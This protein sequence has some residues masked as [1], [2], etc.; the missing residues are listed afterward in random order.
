MTSNVIRY[1]SA[2]V[3]TVNTTVR[4][5]PLPLNTRALPTFTITAIT[6]AA[7]TFTTSAITNAAATTVAVTATPVALLAG[8]TLTFTSTTVTLTADAPQ[9]STSLTIAPSP[10][11]IASAATATY[12]PVANALG[13]FRLFVSPTATFL[14]A[15]EQL[16]FGG[17]TAT[18]TRPAPLGSRVL[19][20]Q[21]LSGAVANNAT[22]ST[23]ALFT[24]VGATDASPSS[25]PKTTDTTNYTSGAG[26]EMAIIGTNRTL[27]VSYNQIN[28][29]LGAI[30]I[31]QILFNDAQFNR[32]VYARIVRANGEI[33][34]G[35][36]IVTSGDGQS[37]VQEKVTRT[38]NMQFQ[39]SSFV[40]TPGTI[41]AAALSANSV[42][43]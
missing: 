22:A 33:Y 15:G 25:A 41:D 37:P 30:A 10:G 34:E 2:I 1:P 35:A 5:R 16:T 8:E 31:Q 12:T 3:T 7:Q 4:L 21:A 11:S 13:N 24:L 39:G 18:L 43:A 14:D 19:F 38:V 36:A 27:S 20:C 40:Y 26:M 23:I 42:M 17:V 28:G 29:D 32:E 6:P 9:G